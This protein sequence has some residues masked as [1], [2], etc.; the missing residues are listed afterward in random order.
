MEC[1]AAR[2]RGATG[3]AAAPLRCHGSVTGSASSHRSGHHGQFR[4][5]AHHRS[6]ARER[7]RRVRPPATP[8]RRHLGRPPTAPRPL[9]PRHRQRRRRSHMLGRRLRWGD[10]GARR[11]M[12]PQAHRTPPPCTE[13]TG[14]GEG[15]HG[16]ARAGSCRGP[17]LC[18][19]CHGRHCRRRADRPR[20]L[21]VRGPMGLVHL[22][23]IKNVIR[24]EGQIRS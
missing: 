1:A 8:N 10:H 20:V 2:T 9:L 22:T 14:G 21:H 5:G 24:G 6:Q 11:A 18:D 19:R 17:A 13:I 15:W 4:R 3:G 23:A 7:A 16:S 12:D